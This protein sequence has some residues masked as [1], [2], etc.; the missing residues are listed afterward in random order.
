MY[1]TKR[2]RPNCEC[3]ESRDIGLLTAA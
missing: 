1:G 2:H 3:W